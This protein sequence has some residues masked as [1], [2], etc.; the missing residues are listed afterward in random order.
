MPVSCYA[1]TYGRHGDENRFEGLGMRPETSNPLTLNEHRQLGQELRATN[2]RLRQLCDMMVGVYG[3][4]NRAAFTFMKLAEAMERVCKDM[5]AQASHDL[6][7]Y[8]SENF[9]L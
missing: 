4:N 1:K 5:E 2:R 3:P 8:S 7:G 6:P 9:Y